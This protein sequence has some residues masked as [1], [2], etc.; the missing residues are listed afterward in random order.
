MP[1]WLLATLLT[2][3]GL[4]GLLMTLCG[5]AVTLSDLF[6]TPAPPGIAVLGILLGVGPG[7]LI[8]WAIGRAWKS[9]TRS[10]ESSPSTDVSKSDTTKNS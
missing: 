5:A 8:V 6:A 3:A 1:K 10:R 4:V 7:L 2:L 9:A